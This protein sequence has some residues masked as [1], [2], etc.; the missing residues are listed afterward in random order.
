[1]TL[2]IDLARVE[3]VVRRLVRHRTTVDEITRHLVDVGRRMD[4]VGEIGPAVSAAEQFVD[5]VGLAGALLTRVAEEATVADRRLLGGELRSFAGGTAL[6]SAIQLASPIPARPST[7]GVTGAIDAAGV[8]RDAISLA[9][10]AAAPVTL[11]GR[12][13]PIVTLAAALAD[14]VLCRLRVGS[15]AAISTRTTVNDDGDQVYEGSRSQQK[16]MNRAALP[17]DTDL[18]VRDRQMW[19]AEHANEHGLV[20]EQY[21]GYPAYEVNAPD[22]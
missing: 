3:E 18:A 16:F 9:D 7:D 14:T 15:G 19:N 12:S 21:P 11:A 6:C 10:T 22:R 17:L 8:A 20:L 2:E 5:R 1:M 4:L 13:A